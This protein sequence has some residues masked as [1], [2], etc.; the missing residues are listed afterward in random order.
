M[1]ISLHVVDRACVSVRVGVRAR[2]C[3]GGDHNS[4]LTGLT[5]CKSCVGKRQNGYADGRERKQKMYMKRYGKKH[6]DYKKEY[7]GETG[8]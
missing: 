3:A 2:V 5:M 7:V 1:V 4:I 8:S 6:S